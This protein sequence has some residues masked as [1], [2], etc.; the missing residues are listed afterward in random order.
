MAVPARHGCLLE[1]VNDEEQAWDEAMHQALNL[2]KA[3]GKAPGELPV[4]QTPVGWRFTCA[5]KACGSAV[6]G[7]GG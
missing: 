1:D 6:A 2:A 5:A 4:S 3:Q 7:P